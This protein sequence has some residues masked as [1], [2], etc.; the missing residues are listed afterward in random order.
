MKRKGWKDQT[1]MAE[2]KIVCL[3][4]VWWEGDLF[5]ERVESKER[6][7]EMAGGKVRKQRVVAGV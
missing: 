1:E 5:W 2:R 6:E 4:P 3:D 7:R